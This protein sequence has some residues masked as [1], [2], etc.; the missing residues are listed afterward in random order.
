MGKYK[1]SEGALAAVKS[2]NIELIFR[3]QTPTDIIERVLPSIG[4]DGQD[5]LYGHFKKTYIGAA[6]GG[7]QPDTMCE[8]KEMSRTSTKG[9]AIFLLIEVLEKSGYMYCI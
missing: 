3:I 6:I 7:I 5:V 4:L 9:D 8:T 1:I 2:A